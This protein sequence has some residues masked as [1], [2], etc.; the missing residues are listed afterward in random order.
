MVV[1][2]EIYRVRSGASGVKCFI[3]SVSRVLN[4]LGLALSWIIL[5]VKIY[6]VASL[7]IGVA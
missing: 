1:Y 5:D 4:F 3:P 6:G 7:C 2:C